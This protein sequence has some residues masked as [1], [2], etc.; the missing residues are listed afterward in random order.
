MPAEQGNPRNK[1][2]RLAV[3]SL[4]TAV[5]LIIGYVESLINLSFIAPG[6]KLGLANS[7]ACVLV[8]SGDIKGAVAVNLSRI[9]LSALLF[10]SPVS[11]AFSIAGGFVSLAVMV[12]LRKVRFFSVIGISVLGG[13]FHNTVQCAVGVLF[14]GKGVAFYLPV[15]LLSGFLCGAAVGFLSALILKR[16][17]KG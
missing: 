10:G 9:L 7:V 5:C 6:I 12:L 3:W 16:I 14:I 2:K 17:K 8:F 13:V 1:V 11:L 15:L 4:L